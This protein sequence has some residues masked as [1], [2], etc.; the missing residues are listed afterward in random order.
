[1][2]ILAHRG[3]WKFKS[4]QNSLKAFELALTHNYGIET[5]LR[6]FCGKLV[7]SHDPPRQEGILFEQFL[8][9]YTQMAST[10]PLAINIK[11][12]GLCSYV[13]PLLEKYGVENYFIFDMSFPDSIQYVD[14]SL[15]VFARVSEYES[16][17]AT[18]ELIAGIWLDSF[19]G[20]WFDIKMVNN[21]LAEFGYV[22]IVSAELHGR[23][24]IEQWES[25][26]LLSNT[27]N[28]YLCTDFPERAEE[29][30]ND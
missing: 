2:Q 13:K 7:I 3:F 23:D 11:A 17:T 19:S 1:M 29:Y 12:D 5:D 18:S 20:E 14:S 6:D 10:S 16:P 26:K 15:N 21:L 8:S 9:L 24:P 22:A 4:D 30:F 25:L 28:L 27:R